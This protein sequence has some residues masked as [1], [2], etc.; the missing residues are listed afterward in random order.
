M[1]SVSVAVV[2]D[3]SLWIDFLRGR[4]GV[5]RAAAQARRLLMCGPVAA[6]LLRGVGAERRE[7]LRLSLLDMPWAPLG[8]FEWLDAGDAAAELRRAGTPVALPDV[9]IAAAARA[10][11]AQVITHDA[12]FTRIAAAM[13]GLAVDVL[14]RAA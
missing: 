14:D 10:A 2:A 4:Q 1:G 9:A 11:G 13:P 5:L 12:D 3:T 8:V 7:S 6:E